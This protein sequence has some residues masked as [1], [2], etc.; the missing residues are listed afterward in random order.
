MLNK[1]LLWLIA[2]IGLAA[3]DMARDTSKAEINS[4]CTLSGGGEYK[5]IFSNKGKKESSLCEHL[6]ISKKKVE[7]HNITF[8][9]DISNENASDLEN[10]ISLAK[11]L[12]NKIKST[13]TADDF[14]K[15][16]EDPDNKVSY[17]LKRNIY[18]KKGYALSEE[19]CSGLVKAGDIREVSG[20]TRFFGTVP[21][22]IC[23][24]PDSDWT[25]ACDFTSISAEEVN[26]EMYKVLNTK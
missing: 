14:K 25:K 4:K 8:L 12:L 21:M 15:F 10:S 18:T 23:L 13:S 7:A 19:L 26:N 17:I 9:P 16:I 24:K 2:T 20:S 5:C 1:I 3:C 6:L 22:K 11:D